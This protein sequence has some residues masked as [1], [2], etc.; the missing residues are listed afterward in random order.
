LSNTGLQVAAGT[1]GAYLLVEP[2]MP[3]ETPAD[4]SPVVVSA[5]ELADPQKE[6]YTAPRSSVYLS[7]EDIDRFGRV[8]VG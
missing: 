8:S 4:L 7:S 3:G 6:T 1:S 2:R 5:A